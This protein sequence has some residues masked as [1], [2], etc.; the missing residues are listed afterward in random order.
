M[1]I[2]HGYSSC[3]NNSTGNEQNPK[4]ELHTSE[5][6]SSPTTFIFFDILQ[7]AEYQTPTLSVPLGTGGSH[8]PFFTQT[9]Q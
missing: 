1:G 8:F 2:L 5:K 3:K 4:E 7:E 9:G 6:L